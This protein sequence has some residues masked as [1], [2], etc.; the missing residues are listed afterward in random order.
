MT[1]LYEKCHVSQGKGVRNACQKRNTRN[2][3]SIASNILFFIIVI[4]SVIIYTSSQAV[5]V[6]YNVGLNQFNVTLPKKK[7]EFLIQSNASIGN[8]L[9]MCN[10]GPCLYTLFRRYR[11]FK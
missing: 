5:V 7:L 2:K 6:V 1:C 8:A 4:L 3:N 11:L 9:L 10:V